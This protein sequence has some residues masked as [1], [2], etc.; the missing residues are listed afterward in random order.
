MTWGKF[1]T[2]TM[3]MRILF[4]EKSLAERVEDSL[5]GKMLSVA[6]ELYVPKPME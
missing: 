4:E 2:A 6:S 3:L 1:A 5:K